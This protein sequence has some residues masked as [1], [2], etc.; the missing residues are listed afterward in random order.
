M[1]K[2]IDDRLT[3]ESDMRLQVVAAEQER[4]YFRLQAEC[5]KRGVEEALAY[6]HNT[7]NRHGEQNT[8][9]RRGVEQIKR[10]IRPLEIEQ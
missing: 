6:L 7:A 5:W 9:Y 1:K 8:W 10:A 4:D 3:P 2:P